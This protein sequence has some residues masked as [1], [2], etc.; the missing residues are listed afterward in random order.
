MEKAAA[1]V[2]RSVAGA[3]AL[4]LLLAALWV[5][6]LAV[7]ANA[8]VCTVTAHVPT[9]VTVNGKVKI[10]ARSTAS[11]PAATEAKTLTSHLVRVVTILPDV[12]VASASDGPR[13]ST[14][15]AAN[16]I[17]CDINN[18]SKGYH[19]DALFTNQSTTTSANTDLICQT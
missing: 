6:G 3:T 11:C 19:T 8:N 16:A 9:N 1:Q 5:A 4:I 18:Q 12:L 7:R 13:K 2:R 10:K 15:Y 14:S 17:G